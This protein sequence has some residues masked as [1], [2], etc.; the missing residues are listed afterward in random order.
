M[1]RCFRPIPYVASICVLLLAAACGGDDGGTSSEGGGA[2]GSVG[3]SSGMPTTGS[4]AGATTGTGAGGAG[5]GGG[6]AT[7][8]CSDLPLCD[9]FEGAAPD[10]PPDTATWS[11]VSPNCSGTGTVTIDGAQAHSGARSLRVNGGGGY[12]D[13]V[14]IASTSAIAAL[15]PAVYGRFFVRFEEAL[16]DSHVTFLTMKDANDN[17]RDL[18][19]GGQSKILMWNRESDDATLPSLSPAGIAQSLMPT[20]D[21]WLCV[22]FFVDQPSASLQTWVDG[23]AI[24]ALQVDDTPTP[25]VDQQWHNQPNW[26]PS[27]TDLKLGWESYGGQTNTLWIDDVALANHRIGCN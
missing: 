23:A 6:A 9:G 4:G 20:P 15:G 25:D 21:T 14:F 16:G 17:D 10:G 3:G 24:A 1:P 11:V 19:M 5:G 18:R 27:L 7:S 2:G 8:D 13:H 22:E 26:S 12:C